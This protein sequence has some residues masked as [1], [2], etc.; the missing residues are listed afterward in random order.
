MT[1]L[2]HEKKENCTYK[3]FDAFKFVYE[4]LAMAEMASTKK[5]WILAAIVVLG[6]FIL[7]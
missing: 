3:P 6:C 7:E 5:G 2:F 1:A 4:Y